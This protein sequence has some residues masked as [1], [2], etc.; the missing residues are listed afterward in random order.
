MTKTTSK[1]ITRRSALGYFGIGVGATML[2]AMPGLSRAQAAATVEEA[3]EWA[4]LNLPNSTP[5]IVNGAAKEGRLVLTMQRF[6]DDTAMARLIDAFKAH[7][8]FLDVEYTLQ[9]SSGFTKK[10]TAEVSSGKGISDYLQLPSD[11]KESGGYITQGAIAEFVVSQDAAFPEI[12]KRSGTWY[13]WLRQHSTTVYRKDAL[14]DEEKQLVRSYEG[15]G[16]PRFKGRLGIN[17][18]ST[19]VVS[20]GSYVLQKHSDPGIWEGIVAN[21]P[22]VRGSSSQLME[23]LLSGGYDISL[24]SGFPTAVGAALS[25]APIEFGVSIRSP[26]LY[27]PGAVSALAPNPNAA[28]LFQDWAMSQEGQNLWVELTGTISSRDDVAKAWCQQQPWFFDD[29]S[30]HVALDWDDF[31]EKNQAVVDKYQAE[32]QQG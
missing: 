10:F 30:T 23:G 2:S 3:V 19:S 27:A 13:A 11:L 7:Y 26:V 29:P 8:P 28:R 6:L 25:G 22:M 18:I 15:L 14:T 9:N 17:N 5:D 24:M 32:L 4:R 20:A 16:D 12:A 31:S 1:D 21:E